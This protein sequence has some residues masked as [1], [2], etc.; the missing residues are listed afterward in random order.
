M[1]TK[2]EIC[3]RE[4]QCIEIDVEW[5]LLDYA[6]EECWEKYCEENGR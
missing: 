6:C 1:M 5:T 2:C 3:E 4:K